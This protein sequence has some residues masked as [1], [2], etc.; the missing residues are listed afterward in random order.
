MDRGIYALLDL[1]PGVLPFAVVDDA[2]QL[3]RPRH[4]DER[5]STR[6]R[7]F[8]LVALCPLC[9]AT[10]DVAD[11]TPPPRVIALPVSD[12]DVALSCEAGCGAAA[13]IGA[14]EQ[15]AEAGW[16]KT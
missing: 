6:D 16:A 10:R 13:L 4:D 7:T 12:V 5:L 11:V 1:I 2:L 3:S 9:A 14:I 15:L 8:A